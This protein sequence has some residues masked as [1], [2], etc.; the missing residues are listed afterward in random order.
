MSLVLDTT[1]KKIELTLNE[2]VT[3]NE[4]TFMTS[5]ADQGATSFVPGSNDGESNGTN[6]VTIISAPSSNVYRL[7]SFI[8]IYN[9]DSETATVTVKLD[10]NGTERTL[11]IAEL[12]SGEKVLYTKEVGWEIYST[13]GLVKESSVIDANDV[14]ISLD[15]RYLLESNNLSDLD[16][17]GTARTNL[18][19]EIGSD[20]QAWDDDLDDIAALSHSI[21][22][23]MVS[24][25]TDWV[26]KTLAETGAILEG[27]IDHGNLQGLSTGA[28][29]SYIDQDVT[30]G[31][32]P[33][34][35]GTN[36]TGI[37]NGALDETYIN[38]DGT[39]SL[40]ANWDIGDGYR[41]EAN[42]IRAR[43]GDGLKLYDDGG[44]GIF[45]EDGGNVGIGTTSPSSALSVKGGTDGISN[46]FSLFNPSGTEVGKFYW[47]AT[48]AGFIELMDGTTSKIKL[49]GDNGVNSYFN[50]GNV[51]IGT[52]NPDR[53][54]HAEESTGL[55]NTVQ[56]AF[57]LSH[58]TSGTPAAGIGVGMEFEVETAVGNN[59]IGGTLEVLTTDVTGASEDFDFVFKNMAGGAAASETFRIASTG[60]ITASG[61]YGHDMNGETIR[62]VQINDSGEF[63]YDSGS[64]MEWK[65]NVDYNADT[66][67]IYDL[68]VFAFEYKQ[69]AD[70]DYIDAPNGI[71]EYGVDVMQLAELIPYEQNHLV[72]RDG[73]GV[74]E[75]INWKKLVPVLIKE[76]QNL[77]EAQ[78]VL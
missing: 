49:A 21:N 62:D 18:G 61:V 52:D 50:S 33:T 36:F 67:W 46:L 43:D 48:D 38:A 72:Y 59:E 51:G 14:S 8:V 45:V 15:A 9:N 40:S 12:G 29:H 30:S 17:A 57:R 6:N 3:T 69:K 22:G 75:G 34:L 58:I 64:R 60:I 41:I 4:L 7:I 47:G 31:S 56:Q 19:V 20:V 35:D 11:Y 53:L 44:N 70:G 77:K 66:S 5:Y 68:D 76:I 27:D 37:P 39:V 32:S 10:N 71:T 2:A 63:G 78:N 16:N 13:T 42:E 54:L 25:G 55:T 26:A 74:P 1:N 23:F 65:T 28:D 24:D 73:D